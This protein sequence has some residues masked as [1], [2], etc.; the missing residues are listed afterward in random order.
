MV[1]KQQMG[2]IA[3]KSCLQ[4]LAKSGIRDE[5][6]IAVPAILERTPSLLG[7]YRLLLGVPQ[8]T[9][10][11]SIT[12]LQMFKS[13]ETKGTI[14]DRQREQLWDL[15]RFLAVPLSDL[16]LK[17]SPELSHRDIQEL[18]LLT[19]GSQFQGANNNIIGQAAAT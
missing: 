11:S 13:M 10:Y 2:E 6:V 8:K 18:P 5:Q 3:P 16:V 1:V 9:F 19:L 12:K 15:C 17:V 4:S 14:N 7:Y